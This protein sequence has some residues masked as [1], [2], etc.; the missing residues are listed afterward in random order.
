MLNAK[1]RNVNS[2]ILNWDTNA[3]TSSSSFFFTNLE[4]LEL[5]IPIAPLHMPLG[6][7]K[8]DY[9]R[10]S[11]N[12]SL[13]LW[14]VNSKDHDTWC[15]HWENFRERQKEYKIKCIQY[16]SNLLPSENLVTWPLRAWFFK[17]K[18]AASIRY[19][20]HHILGKLLYLIIETYTVQS[21]RS[22]P[23]LV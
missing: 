9:N 6:G 5:R 23:L 15:M 3:S 16:T 18:H 14:Q 22:N 20:H 10:E 19:T 8:L 1:L 12:L 17:K 13:Y 2:S 7:W 21:A 11:T 4:E